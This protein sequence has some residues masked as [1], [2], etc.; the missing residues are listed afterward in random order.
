M[1][2]AK[3]K[4]TASQLDTMVDALAEIEYHF[5]WQAPP[6]IV[7][8]EPGD[9]T[10][11]GDE[12]NFADEEEDDS[13]EPEVYDAEEIE[14]AVDAFLSQLIDATIV[15]KTKGGAMPSMFDVFER[16]FGE[17]HEASKSAKE[18]EGLVAGYFGWVKADDVEEAHGCLIVIKESLIK[19]REEAD[20]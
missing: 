17:E 10:D 15:R 1:S 9:E 4:L 2:R 12:E 20:E 5:G 6:Q 18:F 7:P 13:A 16:L 3:K 19:M 14:V 8:G 11:V